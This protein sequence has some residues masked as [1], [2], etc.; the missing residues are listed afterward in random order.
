[1]VTAELTFETSGI[2]ASHLTGLESQ[3]YRC[4]DPKSLTSNYS[5]RLFLF[6]FISQLLTLLLQVSTAARM[7]VR[8]IYIP[9]STL[10]TTGKS[11]PFIIQL[12]E[13]GN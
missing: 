5:H 4:E 3:P 10:T 7:T 6:K 12:S 2:P 1:M 13:N 9:L 8:Y 11:F